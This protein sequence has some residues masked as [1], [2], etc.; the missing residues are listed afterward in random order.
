MNIKAFFRIITEKPLAIKTR[1][2]AQNSVSEF[3]TNISF[4]KPVFHE[5]KELAQITYT[6]TENDNSIII[7]SKAKHPL[8]EKIATRKTI[9]YETIVDPAVIKVAGEN[10]DERR[11]K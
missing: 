10:L 11:P 4:K 6:E 2:V 9:V 5:E 3:T 1:K 8:G 7:S